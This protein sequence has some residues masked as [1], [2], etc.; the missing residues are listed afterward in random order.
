MMSIYD[1]SEIRISHKFRQ[2]MMKVESSVIDQKIMINPNFG[3]A[4]DIA[5][6]KKIVINP[7]FG[8][9]IKI[10]RHIH[11]HLFQRIIYTQIY[12]QSEFRISHK[13]ATSRK[14]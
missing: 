10:D 7:K 9:A 12:D 1:Q 13:N 4:M 6:E 14:I 8:S 11:R 2:N 3:S 5:S